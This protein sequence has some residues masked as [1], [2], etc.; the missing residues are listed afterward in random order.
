M[1]FKPSRF[2]VESSS[3]ILFFGCLHGQDVVGSGR[4][5]SGGALAPQPP[6]VTRSQPGGQSSY[7]F[8]PKPFVFTQ[9]SG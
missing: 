9:I 3:H 8:T 5:A 2:Q 4:A 7:G 6:R 1:I